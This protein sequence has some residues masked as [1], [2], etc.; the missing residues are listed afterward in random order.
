MSCEYCDKFNIEY[1]DSDG[2]I[3]VSSK[4]FLDDGAP[5]NY[6]SVIELAVFEEDGIQAGACFYPLIEYDSSQTIALGFSTNGHHL[7]GFYDNSIGEINIDE[8]FTTENIGCSGIEIEYCPS[9]G[10]YLLDHE[11][12]KG[13]LDKITF[14]EW[15]RP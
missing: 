7:L 1:E 2:V 4:E 15:Q 11:Y 14:K 5:S 8:S 12:I 13:V 9:C 10:Q 6:K 3:L